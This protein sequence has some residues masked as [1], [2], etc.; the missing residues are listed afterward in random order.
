MNN[1]DRIREIVARVSRIIGE[2]VQDMPSERPLCICMGV[3]DGDRFAS[4]LGGGADI[5]APV[6]DRNLTLIAGDIC[7]TRGGAEY[8]S[9][10]GYKTADEA[11]M[12]R[13][14]DNHAYNGER[15]KNPHWPFPTGSKK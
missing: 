8:E 6:F 12:A 11:V 2:V 1:D 9:F 10:A 3:M 14:E 15:D 7:H 5:N 13:P 4:L